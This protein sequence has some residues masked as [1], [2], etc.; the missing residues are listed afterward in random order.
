MFDGLEEEFGLIV[1]LVLFDDGSV[2]IF[3]VVL[4]GFGVV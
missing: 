4:T 2:Q 3:E 1:F